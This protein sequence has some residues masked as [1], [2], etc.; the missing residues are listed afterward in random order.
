[1]V[2]IKKNNL[3]Y[4][5]SKIWFIFKDRSEVIETNKKWEKL[6]KTQMLNKLKLNIA[7]VFDIWYVIFSNINHFQVDCYSWLLLQ[8]TATF[9]CCYSWLLQ[10]VRI[11][12]LPY[13]TLLFIWILK[14]LVEAIK[15]QINKRRVVRDTIWLFQT[16]MTFMFNRQCKFCS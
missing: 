2:G 13:D 1:M 9:D 12:F 15:I 3:I 16:K 11:S 6:N 7:A 10:L 14:C 8:L 4:V 5:K